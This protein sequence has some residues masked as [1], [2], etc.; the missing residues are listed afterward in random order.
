MKYLPLH[1][2]YHYT[3]LEAITVPII[4]QI[5][6]TESLLLSF[7]AS[8]A[9]SVLPYIWAKRDV[10]YVNGSLSFTEISDTV[11]IR[12]PNAICEPLGIRYHNIC[13]CQYCACREAALTTAFAVN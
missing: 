5:P 4:S 9:F 3:Y 7:R 12:Q 2:Q 13:L 8:L 10:V 6:S 1:F 11:V